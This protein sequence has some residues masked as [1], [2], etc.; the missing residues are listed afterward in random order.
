M[1]KEKTDSR[2][3][4]YDIVNMPCARLSSMSGLMNKQIVKNITSVECCKT[5]LECQSP[6]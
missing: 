3:L 6:D 5:Y 2:Q 1:A 4:T